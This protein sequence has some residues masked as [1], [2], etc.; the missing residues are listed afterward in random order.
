MGKVNTGYIRQLPNG[1]YKVI[2]EYPPVN[3]RRT[4]KTK[5]CKTKSEAKR[6][7]IDMNLQKELHIKNQKADIVP[8]KEANGV[9]VNTVSI[10][11]C[12]ILIDITGRK[13]PKK[14]LI[15]SLLFLL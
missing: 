6:T 3:G 14:R 4:K 2:L 8:F 5:I 9:D 1:T 11:A 15:Y 13:R 12:L 10:M 7:L